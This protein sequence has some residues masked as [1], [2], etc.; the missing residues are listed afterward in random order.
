MKRIYNSLRLEITSQCNLKCLYCH[1]DDYSNNEDDM[2]TEEIITLIKNIKSVFPINKILL[3]GGE[4][5]LNKDIIHIVETIT[6]LGI[7]VDL[8]TNGKS[9]TKELADELINAGLKR[10]RLSIDGFEEHSLYRL[11]SDY[12]QLWGMAS[13]LVKRGG[14]NVCI[15][16]VVSPHNV[17]N[18]FNIYNKIV[19]IGAHRW[20]VF[21]IGFMG[22]AMKNNHNSDF[23]NYYD[24]YVNESKKIIEDQMITENYRYLD[25]VLERLYLTEH[26]E[27][28]NIEDLKN[29]TLTERKNTRLNLSACDYISHQ[30]T[31]RSNGKGTF[32]QYFHNEIFD[33]KKYNFD[34]YKALENQMNVIENDI[35]ADEIIYCKKCKYFGLC[36]SGCRS[37]ALILTDNIKNP[38]PVS[39]YLTD[40]RFKEIIPLLIKPTQECFDYFYD[41]NG[42]EP[43]YVL[44]DLNYLLK[45][46]GFIL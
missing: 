20:R 16:T 30:L 25:I 36:E 24:S 7:K 32:C 12:N 29:K 46:G 41:E 45:K 10:I 18:L 26:L 4:P 6:S 13:W 11:G 19:E 33:F 31:I 21:D 17:N 27:L 43:Y 37:K 35:I 23:L 1:N 5:L 9:L 3:T 42:E 15:H 28:F 2:T 8:V 22:G 39:C 38:D 44:K 40:K 34:I 14:V